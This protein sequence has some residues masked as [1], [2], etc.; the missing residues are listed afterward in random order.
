MRENVNFINIVKFFNCGNF[1]EIDRYV[2]RLINRL[3][4]YYFLIL[5]FSLMSVMYGIILVYLFW[6]FD[7]GV[8]LI[9][10]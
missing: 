5:F 3:R 7:F 6:G 4:D 10:I 9:V 1:L 8:V 2:E